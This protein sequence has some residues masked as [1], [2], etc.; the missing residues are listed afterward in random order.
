MA[1]FHEFTEYVERTVFC[2]V[3]DFIWEKYLSNADLDGQAV[4]YYT[5]EYMSRK[6][7]WLDVKLA[8]EIASDIMQEAW[9]LHY[10]R[11]ESEYEEKQSAANNY[12]AWTE[13]DLPWA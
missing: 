2:P 13:D 6:F 12:E 10:S 4:F 7:A 11:M 8:F 1:R 5:M 9:D 3:H